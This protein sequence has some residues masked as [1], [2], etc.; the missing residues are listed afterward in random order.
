MNKKTSKVILLLLSVLGNL[1]LMILTTADPELNF[2]IELFV[3]DTSYS[4]GEAPVLWAR[5]RNTG[6]E[7]IESYHLEAV[8]HVV[9]PSGSRSRSKTIS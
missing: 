6:T 5:V 1:S 7:E 3:P 2:D 9:S 4:N 8:F